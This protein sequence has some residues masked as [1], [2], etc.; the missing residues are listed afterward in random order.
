MLPSA[1]E[2]LP[3][4]LPPHLGAVHQ[5]LLG[6]G[7]QLAGGLEVGALHGARGREGP[8]GTALLLVLDGSHIALLHPVH[9]GWQVLHIHLTT[10]I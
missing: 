6:E 1:W 7:D 3:P 4:H 8:A 2:D 9:M 5:V 10:A